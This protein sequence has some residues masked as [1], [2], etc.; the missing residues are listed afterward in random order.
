MFSILIPTFNNLN[1]LKLCINSI[2]KNS[3]FNHQIIVHVNEGTDGTLDFIKKNNYTY[4]YSNKNIGMPKALNIASKLSHHNYILIS[5]D[6]FYYC[7]GWDSEFVNEINNIKHNNF[8]LSGTMV[9]AGQVSFNAGE[10]IE[11]FNE[12]KLLNNL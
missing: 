1:Y 2:K 10:T 8:Y 6:D 12:Q 7:P 11:E 3:K 9:G 4:T 5:H